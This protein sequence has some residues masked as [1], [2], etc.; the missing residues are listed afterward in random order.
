MFVCVPAEAP[1]VKSKNIIEEY[2]LWAWAGVDTNIAYPLT[3]C[4]GQAATEFN[5]MGALQRSSGRAGG[6]VFERWFL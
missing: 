5:T 2:A 6:K 3:L 4:T 1:E